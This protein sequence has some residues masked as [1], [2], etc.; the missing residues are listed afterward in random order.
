M[1]LVFPASLLI[2]ATSALAGQ[3]TLT[4][5]AR[6]SHP[7]EFISVAVNLDAQCYPSQEAVL[8]ASQG[9]SEKIKNI[10]KSFMS[11]AATA[12]DKI[13]A[14][15][16]FTA[17]KTVTRF[18]DATNRTVVVCE[19]GWSAET[20][21]TLSIA[22]SSVWPKLQREVLQVIDA[23]QASEVKPAFTTITMFEPVPMVYPETREKMTME[24]RLQ[25][26][27]RTSKQ[28]AKIAQTCN[29]RNT[30]MTT[31]TPLV[32][33]PKPMFAAARRAPADDD[34]TF[35]PVFDAIYIDAS[36]QVTWR[37]VDAGEGCVQAQ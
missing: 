35:Q 17:R 23:Y 20:R 1:R 30:R 10:M 34:V 11:T 3:I 2:L 16:G 18:D 31:I 9:A 12:R 19:N 32:H 14:V 13:V 29:L 33:E 22:D 37:F 8:K 15:P 25:A 5:S 24:A 4:D 6:I 27:Q 21:L 36:W 26:L 28:F 7:V